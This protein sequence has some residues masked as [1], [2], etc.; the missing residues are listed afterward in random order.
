ML[1]TSLYLGLT[2]FGGP[3]AHLGYFERTYVGRL[4]WLRAED[5]GFLIGLHRAGG[6]GALA[7]WLGFTLPS[8]LLLYACALLSAHAQGPIALAVVHGLELTAVAVVAQALFRMARTLCPDLRTAAVALAAAATLLA[9]GSERVQLVVLAAGAVAGILFCRG[10]PTASVPFAMP[11]G[12]R[13]GWLA[14]GRT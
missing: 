3:V 4:G 10:A 8:A 5:Y 13:T 1:E 11:L 9:F 12:G 2:S 6:V 14:T 7:A